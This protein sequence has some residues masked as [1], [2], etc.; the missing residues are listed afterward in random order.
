MVVLWE[1]STFCLDKNN[2]IE[3][4][5]QTSYST[6]VHSH[7]CLYYFFCDVSLGKYGIQVGNQ[8]FTVRNLTVNNAATGLSFRLSI[9]HNTLIT[10]IDRQLSL[11]SGIGVRISLKKFMPFSHSSRIH[12]SRSHDQQLSSMR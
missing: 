8:Q 3:F 12:I 9:C 4:T 6:E 2:N 1:V 5:H 7:D 11:A 10:H